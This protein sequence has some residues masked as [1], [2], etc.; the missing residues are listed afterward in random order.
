VPDPADIPRPPA[1]TVR[2]VLAGLCIAVPFIALLWVS[3]F[4]KLAPPLWG[5]PFFYWYQML[6]VVLAGGLTA[7]AY[8]LLRHERNS[9]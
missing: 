8:A 5:I 9:R 6:W 3:S 7:L 1:V 2:R 4:A